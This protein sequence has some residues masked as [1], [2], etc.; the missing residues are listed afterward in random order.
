[1]NSLTD[2]LPAVERLRAAK[3][4]LLVSHMNPDGDAIGS[5]LALAELACKLGV[6]VVI[7]NRDPAPRGL[8]ELPGA[9]GIIVSESLPDDFPRSFDLVVTLEC[10]GLDRPGFEGLDR[11]PI[12]NIDHHKG[13]DRFGE[14]DY[15]D[16]QAPA[17]GEM[18]WQMFE[19]AG[20]RPSEDAA[21][22]AFV[23]LST[24][25]GDF[26]YSNATA[27]AFRAAAAMVDAGAAPE[28]A[29]EIVHQRQSEG[30]IRLLAEVMSTLAL[31]HDG[32]LAVVEAGPEAFARAQAGPQDTENLVN[33]PRTIEG[34][35]VVAFLKQWQPE[36]VRVSLRSKGT[37]NV[38]QV[39]A[40]FGGGGH[41]NASGCTLN[42]DLDSAKAQLLPHLNALLEESS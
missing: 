4:A 1:M 36:V 16:E 27:R 25:T 23:A 3:R 6:E 30:A 22:N 37:L 10:P 33:V 29:S 5:E 39:A 19:C 12:L 34:V 13:N 11:L 38:Q 26:N 17:V 24:D 18:V 7:C 40:R 41:S 31:S 28:K 9:D 8:A 32:A 20:V 35:R 42:G 21:Q 14:V 2:P 15:V